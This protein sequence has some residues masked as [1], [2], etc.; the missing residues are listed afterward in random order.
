[1]IADDRRTG[2]ATA[3]GAG[4]AAGRGMR[5]RAYVV[6]SGTGP[7]LVL[8]TFPSLTDER[9]VRKFA[10]KGILKFI[11]Y[12]VSITRVREVYGVPFEVIAS[13]LE[14]VEDARVLDFNGHHIFSQFPFSEFGD[15][16]KV[17]DPTGSEA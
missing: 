12:E 11:A 8:T 16:I 3:S 15:P 14:G 10:Q 2:P 1:M 13:D 9:L 4:T 6:F 17:G 7:I 5:L